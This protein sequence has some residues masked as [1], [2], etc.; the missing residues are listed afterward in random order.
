MLKVVPL[1]FS[2]R[3]NE[4]ESLEDLQAYARFFRSVEEDK[5][6]MDV[7]PVDKAGSFFLFD[8]KYS[9]PEQSTQIRKFKN[10]DGKTIDKDPIY[11]A[12]KNLWILKP[13]GQNRGK[14]LELFS[15]LEDLNQFLKLYTTGYTVKEFINMQ[16]GDN[17]NISPSLMKSSSQSKLGRKKLTKTQF[18]RVFIVARWQ[19]RSC[20]RSTVRTTRTRRR[21]QA[22]SSRS[23][24]SDR[25]C[26]KATSSTSGLSACLLKTTNCSCRGKLA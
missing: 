8:F 21:F 10:P 23:T 11:F 7:K 19:T 15:S 22:S 4:K 17:D 20:R 13:S 18:N 9:G 5:A 2:F 3:L 24:L 14:G 1:T 6:I 16:Y 25:C 26:S 12:G